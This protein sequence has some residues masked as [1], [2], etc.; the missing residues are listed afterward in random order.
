MLV[1]VFATQG[2][3]IV[4]IPAGHVRGVRWTIPTATLGSL[5]VVAL[6]YVGLHAACVRA[7]PHLAQTT[8]PLV[9]AAQVYGGNTVSWLVRAGT[10]VSALGIAFGMFAM[11]PRY[12][13]VLGTPYALGSWIGQHDRRNVPQHALWI[14]TLCVGVL[15]VMGRLG[16]LVVFSSVAVLTQ[17][18]ASCAALVALAMRRRAGIQRRH[19]WPAPPVAAT[20]L[21][22]GQAARFRELGVTVVVVAVGEVLVV[23]R[24]G[25]VRRRMHR[26]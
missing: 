3:E 13:A 2:F 26:L 20:L 21:F 10:T 8:S 14:T 6:L 22:I 23:I 4:P 24:R 9:A 25:Y 18:A 5:L 15:V 17:F 19:M 16:E 12:L 11:T 1:A 7:L